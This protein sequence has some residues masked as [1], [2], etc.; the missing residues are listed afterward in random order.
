MSES[1]AEPA[2][3]IGGFD[4]N[5]LDDLGVGTAVDRLSFFLSD[6]KTILPKRPTF[7]VNVPAYGKMSILNL[8]A[9]GRADLIILYSQEDKRDIATLLLSR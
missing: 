3:G 6:K 4:G 5:G 1:G 8:N 9:D 2:R 7:A